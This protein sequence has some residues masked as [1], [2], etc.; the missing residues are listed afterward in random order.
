MLNKKMVYCTSLLV[1]ILFYIP[2]G[3]AQSLSIDEAVEFALKH[4][5]KIKQY[6][7]RLEQKKYSDME[8]WGNFLPQ[9]NLV[10][11]YTHLNDPL[12]IDLNPI[13]DAMIQI[14][15]SNQVE[16][17]NIYNLMQGNPPLNDL[18]RSGLYSQ[19][20]NSLN[21]L[22]PSFEKILKKQDYGTA[23]IIGVQPLFVGGKL[24]SAKNYASDEKKSAEV[25]FKQISD[26]VIKETVQNYLSVVLLN[27][28]IK[29]RKDVLVGIKHHKDQAEKLLKEGLIANYHLLRA[30]V[31]VADAEVNLMEDQNKLTLALLS[32]KNTIGIEDLNEEINISD[33]LI[34]API[35]EQI[36]TLV[37]EA[38]NRQ[39]ILQILE[40]KRDEASQ[41]YKIERSNFLPTISAFGK[42]EFIPDDLSALEPHWAVGIQA[43]INLFNG[44]KDY[45]KLQS[46]VHLEEELKYMQADIQRKINLLVNK[47]Y[48]DVLNAQEKYDKIKT[49]ISLAKENLR[50]N[51]KRFETGLGTSLEVI[52]A[53]LSLE[54]NLI[55]SKNALYEYYK[56]LS[57]L[58]QSTGSPEKVL[59]IW[60]KKEL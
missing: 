21:G 41:K 51:E 49:N 34:Y 33:S 53:Q 5:P 52:D 43:S 10:A 56:S 38:M 2:Y 42:Y 7:E 16:F 45:S 8:A 39:P 27:E 55:D 47:N 24:I 50:L 1:F 14:Q 25:E 9:V 26:E 12:S 48:R 32:F 40:I 28:V 17:A 6:E 35:N 31:A 36:D 30:E 3:M 59:T 15:S 46:A 58:Y 11:S 4:N 20:S 57:E 22:L 19:F 18:Q 29:T 44:L 60:N 37:A 23:T 13:R 54:K